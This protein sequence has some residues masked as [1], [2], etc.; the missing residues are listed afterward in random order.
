MVSLLSEILA[1]GS[2][3]KAQRPGRVQ[4]LPRASGIWQAS[5]WQTAA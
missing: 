2:P 1:A 3:V 4:S 5:T